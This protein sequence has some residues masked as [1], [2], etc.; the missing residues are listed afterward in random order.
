MS[1]QKYPQSL[2]PFKSKNLNLKNRIIMGSMHTGLEDSYFDIRNLA[3]YY[4]TRAQND[5]AL[6]VTGGYSPNFSGVL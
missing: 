3:E 1:T 4:R 6:I 5:V 2:S